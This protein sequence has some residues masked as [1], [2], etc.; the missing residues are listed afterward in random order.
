MSKHA[1]FA[2]WSDRKPE[3]PKHVAGWTD[4]RARDDFAYI[5]LRHTPG[6]HAKPFAAHHPARPVTYDTQGTVTPLT[7]AAHVLDV[8]A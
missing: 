1:H 5:V 8:A 2:L 7:P 3:P 6:R 4:E